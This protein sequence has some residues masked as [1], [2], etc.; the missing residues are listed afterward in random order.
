[1]SDAGLP[2]SV[3]ALFADLRHGARREGAQDEAGVWRCGEAGRERLGTRVRFYLIVAGA[4]VL[5]ARY[6]AYGC[7]YTLAACEWLARRLQGAELSALS[8]TGLTALVGAP[9]AWAA[10]LHIPPERLGRLLVIEDA[11]RAAL[12]DGGQ[13]VVPALTQ[14]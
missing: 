6:R 14:P 3:R 4:R 1:M 8:E 13:G 2:P 10:A 12:A 5:Q 9:A 7:P 11:L